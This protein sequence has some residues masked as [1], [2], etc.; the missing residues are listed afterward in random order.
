MEAWQSWEHIIIRCG[1]ALVLLSVW[2]W[3]FNRPTRFRGKNAQNMIEEFQAYGLSTK[4]MYLVG[5]LKISISIC[6]L[7][8]HW[9][10]SLIRPAAILLAGLMTMAVLFHLK[11]EKDNLWKA[12]PAYLVLFFASYLAIM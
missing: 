8:G 4:T 10:P 3:R 2:T 7:C 5:F 1:V 12:G 9:F 11:A 6:F